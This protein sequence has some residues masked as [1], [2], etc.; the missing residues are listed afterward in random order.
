MIWYVLL[1]LLGVG[2]VL[3][4]CDVEGRKGFWAA[5]PWGIPGF[6]VLLLTVFLFVGHVLIPFVMSHA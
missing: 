4:A 3:V 2:L 6:V 1:L 5:A